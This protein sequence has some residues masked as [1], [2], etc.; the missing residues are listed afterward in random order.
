MSHLDTRNKELLKQL[1]MLQ[2]MLST[3]GPVTALPKL[4]AP[5]APQRSAVEEELDNMTASLGQAFKKG[6]ANRDRDD[7]KARIVNAGTV[8]KEKEEERK[9]RRSPCG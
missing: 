3:V 7:V 8:C 1:E 9:N 2:S 4:Q 6:E 5:A